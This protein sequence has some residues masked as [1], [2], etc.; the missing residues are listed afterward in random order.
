MRK[1]DQTLREVTEQTC[2]NCG[3]LLP[4]SLFERYPTGTYRRVCNDCKYMN[5]TLP[6]KQRRKQARFLHPGILK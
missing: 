6:A 3:R 2:R 1:K 5:Y 4:V